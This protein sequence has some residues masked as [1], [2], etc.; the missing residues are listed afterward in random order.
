MGPIRWQ[1]ASSARVGRTGCR[2]A[3]WILRRSSVMSVLSAACTVD[4][5]SWSCGA[6]RVRR[7]W[8]LSP[9]CTLICS[10]NPHFSDGVGGFHP[11]PGGAAGQLSLRSSSIQHQSGASCSTL[12]RR[13]V[14]HC[15]A[16]SRHA[17]HCS[18]RQMG[19]LTTCPLRRTD[20]RDDSLHGTAFWCRG[21]GAFHR[22]QCAQSMPMLCNAA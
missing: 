19:S 3:G 1:I 17:H 13:K 4:C 2:I 21:R 9:T 15:S 11:H 6:C 16:R 8:Y 14:K 12:S 18:W 7:L 10:E 22:R 20:G 5:M